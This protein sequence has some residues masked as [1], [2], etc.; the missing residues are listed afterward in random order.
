M[1]LALFGIAGRIRQCLHSKIILDFKNHQ[2]AKESMD[3][4]L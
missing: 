3:L 4:I 2:R 1:G